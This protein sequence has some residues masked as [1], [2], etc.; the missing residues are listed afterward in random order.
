MWDFFRAVFD[1]TGIIGLACIAEAG[2]LYLLLR[3]YQKKD[4]RNEELQNQILEMSERRREDAVEC[5]EEYEELAQ[6]LHKSIDILIKV[7]QKR[8]G[9]GS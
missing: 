4:N 3:A 9:N 8:N 1:A 7:Y 6:E 5:R 2:I